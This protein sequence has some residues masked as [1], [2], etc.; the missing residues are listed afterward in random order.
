MFAHGSEKPLKQR[1][2]C[3]HALD[4]RIVDRMNCDPKAMRSTRLTRSEYL[5]RAPKQR[6]NA[7]FSA[8]N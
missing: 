1:F 7:C 4:E 3:V 6:R 2:P 5:Q 8:S